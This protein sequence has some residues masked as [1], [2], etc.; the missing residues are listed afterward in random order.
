MA[1]LKMPETV[2]FTSGY[3]LYD[4]QSPKNSTLDKHPFPDTPEDLRYIH[5]AYPKTVLGILGATTVSFHTGK[6][7]LCLH[8]VIS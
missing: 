8:D 1:D 5:R 3:T 6:Q 2:L 7:Y 4:H